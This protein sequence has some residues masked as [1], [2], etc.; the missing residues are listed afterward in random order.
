MYEQKEQNILGMGPEPAPAP[1]MPVQ[2]TEFPAAESKPVHPPVHP[3]EME[4]AAASFMPAQPAEFPAAE[5][6][7]ARPAA[8][9]DAPAGS[10]YPYYAAYPNA[11]SS[12]SPYPYHPYE[13]QH[14]Y[15]F[16]PAPESWRP[17]A[18]PAHAGHDVWGPEVP[19][20]CPPP[21]AHTAP[22]GAP[23]DSKAK[24]GKARPRARLFPI[25]ALCL[26][27]TLIG[28]AVGGTLGV[29]LLPRL[30]PPAAVTDTPTPA[31]AVIADG[32]A[33]AGSAGDDSALLPV[34]SQPGASLTMRQIYEKCNPSVVAIATETT[35]RNVFGQTVTQPAAG[36]GFIVSADGRIV[37]N[38]HVIESASSVSVTLHNG[39]SYKATVVG[40]DAE[41][42]LAALK[43]DATG[44]TPLVWGD[45]KSLKV[46]DPAIAIGNP[47]GELAN[48]MTSG[49]ISALDR[50][51]NID[52][53][54][55]NMLQTDASIS[56]GNS[57][58]PLINEHGQTVGI[59]TAKST[60]SGVEGLGFAIPAADARPIID[61]LFKNGRVTGRPQLGIT[62]QRIEGSVAQSYR[63][64]PGMYV[65]SVEAGSCA[66]KAGLRA[67][68]R[69]LE[70]GGVAVSTP[71]ELNAQK[72]KYKAGATVKIKI[73]RNGETLTPDVVL[74][75]KAELPNLAAEAQPR[76]PGGFFW[77]E[78]SDGL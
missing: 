48:T 2:P 74:D 10:F 1:F 28:G 24:H 63:V 68:D 5:S 44:L 69:I 76:T 56:P 25:V 4:S 11:P 3:M 60:G 61:D 46:G 22:D 20:F 43:I 37:T 39:K 67:G 75:E 71:D 42:D 35:V 45:S 55:R 13:P 41:T 38:N 18:P 12:Y 62:V 33:G 17:E 23:Q 70:F 8:P 52:G 40:R 59:I 54:P 36:S 58:G 6:A 27:F 31:E 34:A 19:A 53:T 50:A 21:A 29:S 66:D 32:T 65:I 30:Q 9:A 7:P 15:A 72:N 47:L 64:E 14:P 57:G 78:N 16:G 73:S 51:I 26:I 77:P 49:I